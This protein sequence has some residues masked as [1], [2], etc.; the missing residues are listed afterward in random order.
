[1]CT[2]IIEHKFSVIYSNYILDLNLSLS[3]TTDIIKNISYLIICVEKILNDNK[4]L[5]N[6][7][8]YL[9]DILIEIYKDNIYEI[10]VFCNDIDNFNHTEKKFIKKKIIRILD[11]IP[12]KLN[13]IKLLEEEKIL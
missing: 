9:I 3:Y 10:T 6:I 4:N 13:I 7:E 11:I 5:I 2:N 12:D 8:S 1:M